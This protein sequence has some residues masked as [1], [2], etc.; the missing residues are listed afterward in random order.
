M[1]C[2][3]NTQIEKLEHNTQHK[4]QLTLAEVREKLAMFEVLSLFS[5][6][7]SREVTYSFSC[8]F[9][10]NIHRLLFL[11]GQHL[12]LFLGGLFKRVGH[13]WH[14]TSPVTTTYSCRELLSLPSLA[15]SWDNSEV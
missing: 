14:F 11:R 9:L 8:V 4:K 6:S 12:T 15:S 13:N 10:S 7:I 1:F 2:V 3:H 5:F